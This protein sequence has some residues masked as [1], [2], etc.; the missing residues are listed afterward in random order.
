MVLRKG[1]LTQKVYRR[2]QGTP[3][4]RKRPKIPRDSTGKCY[5]CD[6]FVLI[7]EFHDFAELFVEVVL[8]DV[9]DYGY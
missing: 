3:C 8:P 9:S 1:T 5:H 7:G 4:P 2:F 6:P